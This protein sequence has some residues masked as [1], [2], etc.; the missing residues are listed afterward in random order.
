M[1]ISSIAF[2]IGAILLASCIEDYPPPI[3]DDD[4]DILVV[5][6]SL[7]TSGSAEVKLSRAIALAE[8]ESPPVESNAQVHIEDSNGNIFPLSNKG[9]GI[10][11]IDNIPINSNHAYR[12][13]IKRGDN[14]E[15][16]SA[17][18][19]V[20]ST[21]PVDSLAWRPNQFNDGI[22]ILV[23]THDDTN[24]TRYYQWIFEETYEYT[25][26][27]LSLFKYENFL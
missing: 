12:L 13:Y 19:S 15:Y 24:N 6:G 22:E 21:P 10:Y 14:R 20:K 26:P 16:L 8:T 4:L 18:V 3:A 5:D 25:S 7:N 2:S 27:F 9:K 1:K 17:F 11:G 23:N